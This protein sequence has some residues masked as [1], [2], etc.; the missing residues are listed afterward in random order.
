VDYA[1]TG[2]QVS[3]DGGRTFGA[4]TGNSVNVPANVTSFQVKVASL[5]DTVFEGNETFSLRASTPAGSAS[6]IGTICEDDSAPKVLSIGNAQANEGDALCFSVT[7]SNAS[8]TTTNVSLALSSGTATAGVDFSTAGLQVSFDGGRS[9]SPV[10]GPN[11][12][13]PAGATSFQV[14]VASI[15]DSLVEPN[16][17]F[18]LQASANGGSATGIGTILND[19]VAPPPPPPPLDP[20]NFTIVGAAKV[21]EGAPRSDFTIR[22]NQAL[23]QDVTITLKVSDLTAHRV[24]TEAANQSYVKDQGTFDAWRTVLPDA[25]VGK[26]SLTKDYTVY[27]SQG[28]IVTGDT[29]TVTIRAG[30]LVSSAFGVQA[31]QEIQRV[32]QRG[33]EIE[34]DETFRV[35]ITSLNG[36]APATRVGNTVTICDNHVGRISPIIIDMDGDGVQTTGIDQ[37]TARFDMDLDGTKDATGWVSRT[38]ALLAHD[39]NRDGVINDRSELFGGQIGEGFAKLDGFDSNRDGVVDANDARFQE[40]KLWQDRDGDGTTDDGELI[41]L[42]EAGLASLRTSYTIDPEHQNGNMLIER[43]SAQCADGRQVDM[44]DAYFQV[45]SGQPP[46]LRDILSDAAEDTI[47]LGQSVMQ[48]K[49]FGSAVAAADH[50]DNS[51][52]LQH[53]MHKPIPPTE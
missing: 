25:T 1:I 10:T 14:K 42:S 2:L 36:Q 11:L 12:T 41:G 32:S 46:Q 7:L 19:D 18:T 37:S 8:T 38:D 26:A 23:S 53:L 9:F 51:I 29:V 20:S 35:E 16:E 49:D 39:A 47:P 5:E 22:L 52:D 21:L 4:I 27:D 45:E 24:G 44:V 15:E 50:G 43:S 28:N 33:A 13:V 30:Q 3:F 6:G 17:T 34:G 48:S 40:L 31:W